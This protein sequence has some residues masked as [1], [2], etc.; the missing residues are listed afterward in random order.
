MAPAEIAFDSASSVSLHDVA[1][2][3]HK[4]EIRDVH[5]YAEN[6]LTFLCLSA[7]SLLEKAY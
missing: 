2:K 1:Y 4:K 7:S 5:A 3:S 6:M